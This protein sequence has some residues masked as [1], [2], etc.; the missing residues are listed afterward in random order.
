MLN[1]LRGGGKFSFWIWCQW[2]RS[3]KLGQRQLDWESCVMQQNTRW[4]ISKVI[5]VSELAA[6]H[7]TSIVVK[8]SLPEVKGSSHM[9]AKNLSKCEHAQNPW[10]YRWLNVCISVSDLCRCCP[11]DHQRPIRTAELLA[12]YRFPQKKNRLSCFALIAETLLD[13]SDS[14]ECD[15]VSSEKGANS[16]PQCSASKWCFVDLAQVPMNYLSI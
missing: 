16:T 4:N 9:W 5:A 1:L 15:R 2:H 14:R 13:L 8:L 3:E 10:L 11:T 7:E 6:D 12:S